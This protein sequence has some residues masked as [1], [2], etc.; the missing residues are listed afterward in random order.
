MTNNLN[1]EIERPDYYQEKL[2]VEADPPYKRESSSSIHQHTVFELFWGATNQD[3]L[4]A[5]TLLL[6]A[7]LRYIQ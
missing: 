2:F 7:T 5:V 1:R 3:V 6:L 4:L